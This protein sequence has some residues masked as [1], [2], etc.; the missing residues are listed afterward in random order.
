LI[1]FQVTSSDVEIIVTFLISFLE[2]GLL[3]LERYKVRLEHAEKE[4]MGEEIP[5]VRTYGL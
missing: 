2:G 1:S 4:K 3:G 5:G